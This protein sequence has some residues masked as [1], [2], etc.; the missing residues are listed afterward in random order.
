MAAALLL[1][2][3]LT[4]SV[5]SN[6]VSKIRV[7]TTRWHPYIALVLR[8]CID[9]FFDFVKW[10]DP[11]GRVAG[12][13]CTPTIT[14]LC[15]SVNMLWNSHALQRYSLHKYSH[16]LAPRVLALPCATN[17]RS[18]SQALLLT[19]NNSLCLTLRITLVHKRLPSNAIHRTSAVSSMIH[20]LA[21]SWIPNKHL[22]V[23]KGGT[24]GGSWVLCR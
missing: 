16:Y 2:L 3:R 18:Y 6:P 21:R 14:S 13:S 10:M 4:P 11:Y 12:E 8:S 9:C 17:A 22:W 7:S 20:E 23:H 15:S 5:S 19:I 1:L 24:G